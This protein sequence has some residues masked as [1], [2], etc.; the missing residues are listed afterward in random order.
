MPDEPKV[1]APAE[2]TPPPPALPDWAQAVRDAAPDGVLRVLGLPGGDGESDVP[3]F[4][5]AP[6][7]WLTVAEAIK[8]QGFDFFADLGAVDYPEDAA[9]FAVILHLRDL[10]NA[11]LVRLETR[12][13]EDTVVPSVEGVFPA[14]GWPEREA[15]DLLGVRFSGNSDMRRLL[16]PDDWEG[17][18]LR[19]DYPLH[20]P[21]ALD[22]EGKYAL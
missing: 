1:E 16:L 2:E 21:R 20:G 14:A 5:V 18:P 22:P 10:E 4:E 9:R 15:Y 12:V 11:R 17:H 13:G 19:R 7:H 6:A 3:T 8:A